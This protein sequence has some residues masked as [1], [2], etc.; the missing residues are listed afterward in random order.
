MTNEKKIWLCEQY[1]QKAWTLSLALAQEAARANQFGKGYAIV[2]EETRQM[3]NKLFEY[4]AKVK[5]DGGD[6]NM[7]KSIGDL[8]FQMGLLSVNTVVEVLR[9]NPVISDM[10]IN[11]SMAV[12]AEDL[13]RLS[14]EVHALADAKVEQ[15]PYIWPEILSPL[16]SS[17]KIDFFFRFSIGGIQLVEN[18]LHIQEV[19]YPRRVDT[20]GD[21]FSLRGMKMPVINC[22][23]RFGLPR[24]SYDADR[25][26]VM[27]IN[28]NHENESDPL[29]VIDGVYAVPID[30]LDEYVV[31]S[32]RIGYAVP[33]QA[34][35][36]F[37]DFARECWDAVG[38]GQ[39]I[40]VDWKKMIE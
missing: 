5:F 37:S 12:L 13:R 15:K 36:V 1:A 39:L 26:T 22:Y 38:G 11:K 19:C 14:V 33:P 10:T 24:E 16:K 7:L 40:F 17:R 35:S 25:Q 29:G 28:P 23:K 18:P 2:A 30:D 9:I 3:A 6:E 31:F 32:S 4:S 34:N 8:A 21:I 20:D 27:L